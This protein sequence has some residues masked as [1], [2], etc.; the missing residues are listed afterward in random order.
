[1]KKFRRAA[2]AIFLVGIQA[3]ALPER[4]ECIAPPNPEV[5]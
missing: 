4:T 1:M 5:V 2:T 3:N